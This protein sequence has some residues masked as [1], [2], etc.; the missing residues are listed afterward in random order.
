M[1]IE[2]SPGSPQICPNTSSRAVPTETLVSL[3]HQ[4][5]AGK[6]YRFPGT[7]FLK[8][9]VRFN[10]VA[11]TSKEGFDLASQKFAFASIWEQQ[12]SIE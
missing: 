8:Q 12:V 3:G 10:H 4:D 11:S 9:W 1:E 2:L 7:Y 6:A 5:K